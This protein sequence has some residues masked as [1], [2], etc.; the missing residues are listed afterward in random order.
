MITVS[1]KPAWITESPEIQIK[2]LV[3][4]GERAILLY[5][6]PRTG[7]TRA[8]DQL[9]ERT[10]DDRCTIQLHEGWGYENLITGFF[11]DKEGNFDGKMV[12]YCRRSA[13]PK[14]LLFW[15]K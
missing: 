6:P 8:I 14:R 1:E 11:P 4:Q 5:G 9:F 13:R 15:K 2:D 10:S 12:C 7:K 3:E